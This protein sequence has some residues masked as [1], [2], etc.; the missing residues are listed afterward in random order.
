MKR[1]SVC[2]ALSLAALALPGSAHAMSCEQILAA[3]QRGESSQSISSRMASE[4]G[5]TESTLQC[6]VDGGAPAW[7]LSTARALLASQG[8]SEAPSPSLDPEPIAAAPEPLEEPAPPPSPRPSPK[9]SDPPR[10]A[11]PAPAPAPAPAARPSPRRSPAA[12][13]PSR[14]VIA[15][16]PAYSGPSWPGVTVDPGLTESYTDY[17]VNGFETTREDPWSTFAADVDN[18]SYT[19]TRRKLIEGYLPPQAAV[20][21]EEFVNYLPYEYARPPEGAPFGVDV[22][23]AHNPWSETHIVR[24]GVQGKRVLED[25]RK[26]VH[27]TFLVDTSGSMQSSDKLPLVKRALTMLSEELED[28]D[29]VSLVVYAG[30]A[31]L[32][33]PP[34]PVSQRAKILQALAQLEAGGSTAMGAGIELAYRQARASYEDGAVNRVI[35]ASDGDANVGQTDHASLS[36]MI[37]GYAEDGI[38]LTTLGFGEGNYRDTTM[39]Q[40]ANDGDGN[41]FYLDSERE[42][43]RVLVD[44]MTSTLEVIA[45]DVKI[46]VEFSPETVRSYRLIGYENR[47]VADRDFRNDAVD[48]GEIGSGHQVTALYE[49]RWTGEPGPL[50]R[51]RIRHQAPGPDAPHVERDYALAPEVNADVDAASRQ[52][53]MALASA[54]FAEILRG[55]PYAEEVSL[56]D[57]QWLA[58]G[59]A[60]AEYPEDSELV[61]LIGRA[62]TLRGQGA[63]SGM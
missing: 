55:S 10:T 21:A 36:K 44:K 62:I 35:I 6:L 54:T 33:L 14:P 16:S 57:V 49:V 41:Y 1:L 25:R 52:F 48:G 4:G 27:L 3:I 28:G 18:G 60:R 58:R 31:G 37:R 23:M 32:V 38:T 56:A 9:P 30:S 51:V 11:R 63:V 42:A 46:Q 34:T 24:I 26:P 2:A 13:A 15:P 19:M 43:Q 59:A 47:D 29:T 22:E 50:G 7:A 61:Q 20:R 40:I 53:R 45:K 12:V 8:P 5:L 17:G 39:E